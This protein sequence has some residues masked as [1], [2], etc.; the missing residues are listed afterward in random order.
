MIDNGRCPFL[1]NLGMEPCRAA[2]RGALLATRPAAQEPEVVLTVDFAHR[3]SV[4][5]RETAPLACRIATR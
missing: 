2:S 5:A 3:E 1:G 4:L